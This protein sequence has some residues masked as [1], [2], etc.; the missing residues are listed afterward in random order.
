M[1]NQIESHASS[2]LFLL[3][4]LLLLWRWWGNL[5]VLDIS[6]APSI[7]RP[8]KLTSGWVLGS[9]APVCSHGE[10]ASAKLLNLLA[11]PIQ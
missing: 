5:E 9:P 3:I 6:L 2:N 4:L 8:R 11:L 10:A 7:I 1:S